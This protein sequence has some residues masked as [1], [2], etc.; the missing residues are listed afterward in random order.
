MWSSYLLLWHSSAPAIN[1]VLEV[2]GKLGSNLLQLDK[3]QLL[4]PAAHLPLPQMPHTSG[5][6]ASFPLCS[7]PTFSHQFSLLA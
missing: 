1:F 3:L 2:W 4:R 7:H 6:D 5:G